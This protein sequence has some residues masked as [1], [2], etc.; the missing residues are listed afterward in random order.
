MDKYCCNI[1]SKNYAS[2]QSLWIHNKKFHSTSNNNDINLHK[3][4]D[5]SCL[6]S[7]KSRLILTKVV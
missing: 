2:Y 6:N 3:T 5:K 7:D 4:S 1:C